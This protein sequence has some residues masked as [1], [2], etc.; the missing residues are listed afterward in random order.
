MWACTVTSALTPKPMTDPL[1]ESS[2]NTFSA[3]VSV[4]CAARSL[5][6]PRND[7]FP[8]AFQDAVNGS[9]GVIQNLL[10]GE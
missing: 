5:E 7:L 2:F 10:G 9:L 8:F 3:R 4:A 1:R 6:E